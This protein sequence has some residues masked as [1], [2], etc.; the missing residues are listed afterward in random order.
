MITAHE[1]FDSVEE[2][3]IQ[4]DC[5]VRNNSSSVSKFVTN[6][7]IG[8][9]KMRFQNT[10]IIIP[11]QVAFPNYTCK[12]NPRLWFDSSLQNILEYENNSTKFDIKS[13]TIFC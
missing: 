1:I 9:E 8:Y 11:E 13:K 7:E 10:S 5:S 6:I 12:I 4:T 3:T 2:N